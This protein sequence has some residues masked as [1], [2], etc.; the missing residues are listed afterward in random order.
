MVDLTKYSSEELRALKKDIDKALEARRKDDA[1]KA[2]QEMK[3]IAERYGFSVNEL[4]QGQ[5]ARSTRRGKA[6]AR[7][8]HPDDAS[9]TWSGRGRKP[10]WVKDWEAAGRSLEELRIK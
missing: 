8:R 4:V 1:K 7:F 5:T 2:Q 3:A 10:V 6:P 9:K